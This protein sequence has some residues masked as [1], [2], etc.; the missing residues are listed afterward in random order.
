MTPDAHFFLYIFHELNFWVLG[1]L[2]VEEL[3]FFGACAGV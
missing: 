1:D 2:G 3:G